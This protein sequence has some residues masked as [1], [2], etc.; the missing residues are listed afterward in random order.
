MSNP[1]KSA[2]SSLRATL[3]DNWPIKVTALGLA[4]ALWAAVAAQE[5]TTQIVPVLLRVEPPPGRNVVGT[6]PE[7]RALFRGIPREL[8]KLYAEAPVIRKSLPD[9][10]TGSDYVLELSVSDI[11]VI[12]GAAVNAQQVEP[13]TIRIVLDDVGR[14]SVPVVHRVTVEPDSGHQIFGG[15]SVSPGSITIQGPQDRVAAITSVATMPVTLTSVRAPVRRRVPIDTTG[16]AGLQLSPTSVMVTAEV[17]ALADRVF[18]GVR[19]TL[20]ADDPAAW[21][22]EPGTV[23]V[24]V[25]GRVSRMSGLTRDSVRVFA[26][27]PADAEAGVVELRVVAPQGLRARANP[28]SVTVAR[29]DGSD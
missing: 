7:V 29:R 21:V 14:K 23:N 19:V 12:D 24:I 28:D 8:I 27:P 26:G 25:T 2:L 4:A 10:I 22:A 1:L 18:D 16:L 9:T 5:P 20:E 11:A 13:Q 15:L 17:S 6:V 3:I